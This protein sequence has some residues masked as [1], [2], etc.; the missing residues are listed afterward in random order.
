MV[1]NYKTWRIIST[2]IFRFTMQEKFSVPASAPLAERALAW[3][4]MHHEA[5]KHHVYYKSEQGT[6]DMYIYKITC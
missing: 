2:N 3:M 5:R 6:I 1:S 4:A